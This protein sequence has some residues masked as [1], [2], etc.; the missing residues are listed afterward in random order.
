MSLRSEWRKAKEIGTEMGLWLHPQPDFILTANHNVRLN[1]A[2][3]GT[4]GCAVQYEDT[5]NNIVFIKV[6][7]C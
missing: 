4:S 6:I 5:L 3:E 1:V 2:R 7:R